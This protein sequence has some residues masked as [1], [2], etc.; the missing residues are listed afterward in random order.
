LLTKL[1]SCCHP[2]P[3]DKIVGY[4]TRGRGVTVHRADCHNVLSED[5][6]ERLVDV[7]WGRIEQESFP[8]T[9]RV[10]AWDREGLV[11]DITAL[12]ADERLNIHGLSAVVHKDQTATVWC[13]VA[14]TGLDALSRIMS[15]LEGV[16]DVFSVVREVG[17][18][19]QVRAV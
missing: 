17:E 16:R 2:V 5:E 14:V 10:D 7:D 18:A 15:R 19:G 6:A 11:R 8:V 4:I 12:I 3:G 1:A 13:T 9:V